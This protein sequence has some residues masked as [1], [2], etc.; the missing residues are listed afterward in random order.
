MEFK[1]S[2]CLK[3]YIDHNAELWKQAEEGNKIKK[4]NARLR[5]NTMFDKSIENPMNPFDAKV[6]SH[7]RKWLK[8]L[9]KPTLRKEKQ[10]PYWL[11]IIQKNKWLSKPTHIGASI[12]ELRQVLK[13]F[14]LWMQ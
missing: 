10:L 12:L 13:W 6:V 5:N 1:Q 7:Y 14:S 11:I 2:A 4:Q 3:L 8:S 9:Y